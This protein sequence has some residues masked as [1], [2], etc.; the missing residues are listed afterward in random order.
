MWSEGKRTGVEFPVKF[1]N[2]LVKMRTLDPKR[3]VAQPQIEQLPV[4]H[5]IQSKGHRKHCIW[6]GNG[7]IGFR[8]ETLTRKSQ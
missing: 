6:P 3:Q 4:R 1:F 7:G 2:A 8:I 5:S